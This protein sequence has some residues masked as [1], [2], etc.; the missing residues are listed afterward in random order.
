MRFELYKND[1][2]NC[3][4]E[5]SSLNLPGTLLT[6]VYAVTNE[7][8]VITIDPDNSPVWQT[9]RNLCQRLL[10]Q[11]D[12]D[13]NLEEVIVEAVINHAFDYSAEGLRYYLWGRIPCPRCQ[14]A[15]RLFIGPWQPPKFIERPTQA[16]RFETWLG[17]PDAEQERIASQIALQIYRHHSAQRV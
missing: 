8:E 14:F 7:Q 3:R 2:A 5:F 13:Q 1:C 12:I 10:L 4:H 17:L 9:I 11:Q 15:K 6:T 16:A